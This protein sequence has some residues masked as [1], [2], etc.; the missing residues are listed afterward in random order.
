[1][2][3]IQSQITRKENQCREMLPFK[4]KSEKKEFN[5][6]QEELKV[7]RKELVPLSNKAKTKANLSTMKVSF[8][9]R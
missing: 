6:L 4:E 8:Y 2:K 7:L 1:M 3:Q 5:K 9:N